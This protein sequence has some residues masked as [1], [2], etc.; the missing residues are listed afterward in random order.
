M[1]CRQVRIPVALL[2]MPV[3]ALI[4]G[5]HSIWVSQAQ[6]APNTGWSSKDYGGGRI[7]SGPDVEIL[8]KPS[9][10]TDD[11]KTNWFGISLWF[12]PKQLDLRFSP[13]K[14]A[15][16]FQGM[17][18]IKPAR[19]EMKWTGAGRGG[20]ECGRSQK[21]DFGSGPP[22]VL[23]RGFCVEL[24]FDIKPPSPD[25]PFTLRITGLTREN[26]PVA[27]PDIHFVKGSVT[28]SHRQ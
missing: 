24:Y 28:V 6:V 9:N 3:V 10:S 8:V 20:W 11:I 12:D 25:T 16:F 15:L 4:A 22:Y 1:I 27:I 2:L 23:H 26:K 17:D 21:S 7:L 14:V 18:E 5:C 13:E 19:I